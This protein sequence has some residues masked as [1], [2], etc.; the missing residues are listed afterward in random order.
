MTISQFVN[1]LISRWKLALA[2][3][4]AITL[5]VFIVAISLPRQYTATANLVIDV[6]TPDPIAGMNSP[7]LYAPGYMAT[8]LD[9]LQSDSVAQRVARML[10]LDQ[11]LQ[12]QESWQQA[13]GGKGS[14]YA[15]LGTWLLRG[16]EVKPSR[17][18]NVIELN[19]KFADPRFASLA[20]NAFVQAYIDTTL[21]LRVEP[22][23]QYSGFFN[24]RLKQARAQLER[25]QGKLSEF[26]KEKGIVDSEERID[27]ETARLNA[28]SGQLVVLRTQSADSSS[29]MAQSRNK[30]DQSPDVMAN[31]IIVG[32][33]SDLARQEAALQQM[34][35]RL[36]DSHPQVVEL[37]ANIA[38]LRSKIDAEAQRTVAS[39]G[40]TSAISLARE[41]EIQAA[42]DAQR[43]KLLKMKAQRDE[44]EVLKRDTENAQRNYDAVQAR[45]TQMSLESQSTQTNVSLLSPAVEPYEPSSPRILLATVLAFFIS[46]LLA[47]IIVMAREAF[48]RRVRSGEDVIRGLD[49]PVIGI[50]PKG[51]KKRLFGRR[52]G[53]PWLHKHVVAGVLPGPTAK[54]S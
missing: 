19:Y 15:W 46:I 32:L 54:T 16:L 40:A 5:L 41:G 8:Q 43:G 42:F 11:S 4:L 47:A 22:A 1:V 44:L 31:P 51:Q 24:D 18:S 39:I 17:E 36:G 9:I 34:G 28:L 2:V 35:S 53:A 33:K 25:A 21:E 12:M 30:A 29:R 20:A 45:L 50:M 14:F 10:K 7:A 26:Q 37:R 48:D 49:L 27:V 38:A 3:V 6:K 13:T 52:R 23:K